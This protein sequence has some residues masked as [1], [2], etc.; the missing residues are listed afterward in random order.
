MPKEKTANKSQ[1]VDQINQ[2]LQ[3]TRERCV[4]R[5]SHAQCGVGEKMEMI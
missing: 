3:L 2:K 1:L 5:K 4:R